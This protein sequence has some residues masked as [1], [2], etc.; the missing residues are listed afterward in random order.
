MQLF[1]ISQDKTV[2]SN[3]KHRIKINEKKPNDTQLVKE[4]SS[5]KVVIIGDSMLNNTNNC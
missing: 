3:S 2:C 4:N 1:P 5:N